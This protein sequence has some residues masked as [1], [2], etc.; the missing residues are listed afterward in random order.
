MSAFAL[1][2]L[3]VAMRKL[4][5]AIASIE[6]HCDVY[7]EEPGARSILIAEAYADL[8]QARGNLTAVQQL[9]LLQEEM[10][11]APTERP[12]TLRLVKP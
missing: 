9:L 1:S 5:T 12:A 11:A 7:S 6:T 8:L 4:N 10:E 3:A 2:G